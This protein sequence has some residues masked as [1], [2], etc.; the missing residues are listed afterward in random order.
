MA[1]RK[2]I[3]NEEIITNNLDN[4]DVKEKEIVEV[5]DVIVD[6]DDIITV[7]AETTIEKKDEDLVNNIDIKAIDNKRN[8]SLFGYMWNGQEFE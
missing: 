2:I 5:N 6:D 1:K 3:K 4:N 8:I 7:N